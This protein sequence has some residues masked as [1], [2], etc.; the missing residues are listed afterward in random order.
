MYYKYEYTYRLQ[1]HG[2]KMIHH[3]KNKYFNKASVSVLTPDTV[4]FG[5]KNQGI[6]G[7]F[8]IIVSI[9]ILICMCLIREIK[10]TF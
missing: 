10:N 5:T 4:E 3:A 9:I 7:Y 1:V 2:C 6:M 8:T